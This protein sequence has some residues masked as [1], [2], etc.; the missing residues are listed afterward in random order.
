MAFISFKMLQPHRS[1]LRKAPLQSVI[2]NRVHCATWWKEVVT[3]YR[4]FCTI[5]ASPFCDCHHLRGPAWE[6]AFSIRWEFRLESVL[7]SHGQHFICHC[8]RDERKKKIFI[9]IAKSGLTVTLRRNF[10][11]GVLLECANILLFALSACLE[12]VPFTQQPIHTDI[13]LIHTYCQHYEAVLMEQVIYKLRESP[14]FIEIKE[15]NIHA[16]STKSRAVIFQTG[17]WFG[18]G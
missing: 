4:Q 2:F 7:E 14:A 6:K 13:C 10:D 8:E 18:R 9:S 3:A 12:F 16:E 5:P 1:F 17:F 11:P 15:T